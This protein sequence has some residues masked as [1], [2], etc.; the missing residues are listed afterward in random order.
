M[1]TTDFQRFKA[2]MA[3]MARVFSTE[4]DKPLLDGYWLALR[5]WEIADFEGAA[6]HLMAN[7]KFM[8]KPAD[9]NELRKKAAEQSA[10][11]AWE[12]V[13]H[14]IRTMYVREGASVDPKT[15][16]VV[17]QMG[18]YA[19]LALSNS[20]DLKFRARDFQQLWADMGE[21]EEARTA[22]PSA[23]TLRITGPQG[24]SFGR[25]LEGLR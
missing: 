11:E 21:V 17:R 4:I 13:L 10:G 3:G 22:L 5:D 14:A 9:F 20:E 1:Q 25:L 18:G 16:A 7:S 12:K 15:D 19:H 24:A 6:A 2:V 23:S 8:P